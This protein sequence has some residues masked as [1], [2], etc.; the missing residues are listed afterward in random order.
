MAHGG[1]SLISYRVRTSKGPV[2]QY[3]IHNSDHGTLW[4]WY[5]KWFYS[6][7]LHCIGNR[8]QTENNVERALGNWRR[9]PKAV[10]KRSTCNDT[11]VLPRVHIW[12]G[13]QQSVSGE[14]FALRF[15]YILVEKNLHWPI[16]CQWSQLVW[17][18]CQWFIRLESINIALCRRN[19]AGS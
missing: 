11:R 15:D 5:I 13:W 14:M 8:R 3:V 16:Y 1:W 6:D 9:I 10:P 2:P 7:S 12:I 18:N 19:T 17:F 4:G